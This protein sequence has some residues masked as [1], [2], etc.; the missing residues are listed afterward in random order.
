MRRRFPSRLKWLLAGLAI[1]LGCVDSEQALVDEKT[2]VIDAALIGEWRLVDDDPE[3][4]ARLVIQR[5][6]GSDTVLEAVDGESEPADLLLAK[7]GEGHYLCIELTEEDPDKPKTYG[8]FR[9]EFRG[10]NELGF[11]ALDEAAIYDAITKGKLVGKT[12]WLFGKS[13]RISDDPVA[14]REY[15]Q[16]QGKKCFERDALAVMRRVKKPA[17]LNCTIF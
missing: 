10:D 15:L 3:P 12:G 1:T 6:P 7:I 2:S 14:I 16:N 17:G 11:Y 13:A 9:Y 5:K 8:V 4:S